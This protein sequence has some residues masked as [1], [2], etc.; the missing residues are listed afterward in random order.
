MNIENI[1]KI[2]GLFDLFTFGKYLVLQIFHGQIPFYHDILKS[3]ELNTTF[4]MPSLSLVTIFSV[5]L[6]ISLLFSGYF[7]IKGNKIGAILSYLQA[8]LRLLTLI[9]PSIFFITWPLKY[10]FDS[11]SITKK[12]SALI[13]DSETITALIV[14]TILLLLSESLKLY[15]V[16]KWRNKVKNT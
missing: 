13:F 16:I 4:G 15:S 11:D 2:W 6:Y 5:F 9:P 8:P 1:I 7:L 3:I 12:M 14:V 10:F